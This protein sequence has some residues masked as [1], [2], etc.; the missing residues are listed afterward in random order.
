MI[1]FEVIRNVTLGELRC[2]ENQGELPRL[3]FDL[4]QIADLDAVT[5][6]GDALAVYG[7]VAVADE[8]AG[9][10]NGRNEFRTI[11]HGIE[12]AL[13]QPD[14]VGAGIALGPARVV[15]NA[16]ELSL[17]QVGV[18]A[19]EFLLGAQLHAVIGELALAALAML[20]RA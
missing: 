16:V 9:G 15:V 8:R 1:D 12:T 20:A 11:N 2:F 19:L 17:G 6:N 10:E 3:L 4:D 14:H 13:Q 5:R 18:V 7:D